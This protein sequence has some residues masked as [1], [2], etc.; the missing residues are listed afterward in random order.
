[1]FEMLVGEP[2]FKADNHIQLQKLIESTEMGQLIESRVKNVDQDF[3]RL[4]KGL[5][6]KNPQHRLSFEQFFS[7][8]ALFSISSKPEDREKLVLS[9]SPCLET[10]LELSQGTPPFAKQY[11][12]KSG[13]SS[14]HD[15]I[16]RRSWSL[17]S[18]RVASSGTSPAQSSSSVHH[19]CSE[20]WPRLILGALVK[21][22]EETSVI[23]GRGPGIHHHGEPQEPDLLVACRDI[24]WLCTLIRALRS[25]VRDR[26]TDELV[27][28]PGMLLA[29]GEA[30]RGIRD[31][32]DRARG[33]MPASV[34]S[35]SLLYRLSTIV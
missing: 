23:R 5:L 29:V 15:A 17:N 33:M 4:L 1:M 34:S 24:R 25:A 9:P 32:L 14:R 10:E 35:T 13:T 30:E 28:P 12:S 2:P 8:A 6:T 18:D 3:K 26:G 22:M 31:H 11:L 19:G 7:H 21:S 20:S 16:P 27:L